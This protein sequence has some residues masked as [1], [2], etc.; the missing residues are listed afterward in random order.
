[1]RALPGLGGLLLAVA[2]LPGPWAFARIPAVAPVPV[3]AATATTATT[4]ATPRIQEWASEKGQEMA[5]REVAQDASVGAPVNVSTWS[6]GVLDATDL[7]D[8]T[9][10]TATWAAVVSTAEGPAGVL[11]IDADG[12]EPSGMVQ[13]DAELAA[14]LAALPERA[15]VLRE[16]APPSASAGSAT[17][18]T[19]APQPSPEA[20][21]AEATT[22]AEDDAA[23]TY[24][25][26]A[27]PVAGDAWYALID[28]VVTA[29]DDQ[30]SAGLAGPVG[31]P[32][33]AQ[34]LH[35]RTRGIVDTDTTEPRESSH[36]LDVAIVYTGLGVLAIGV[37]IVTTTFVHER[38]VMAPL[39]EGPESDGSKDSAPTP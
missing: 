7:D 34:V 11:V 8:P 39:R 30:A 13:H 16:P 14:A 10:P 2:L 37:F 29:L 36:T 35:D 5:R 9:E 15:V 38:R 18:S 12:S 1:M 21:P 22:A 26:M 19:A 3:P 28:E 32:V 25:D 31:L 20:T 33:Y 27:D 4:E 23:E 24:A 17:P 6:T